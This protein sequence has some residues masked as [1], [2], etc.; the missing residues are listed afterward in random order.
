M[1]KFFRFF[2]LAALVVASASMAACSDKGS[3]ETPEPGNNGTVIPNNGVAA[4]GKIYLDTSFGGIYFG[5]FWDEG[6]GDYYIMLTN[7]EVGLTGNGDAAPMN[8]GGWILFLDFWGDL[9]ADHTNPILPEG[10]YQ[11]GSERGPNVLTSSYTL[12]VNNLERVEVEGGGYA[13]RII[14]VLFPSGSATVTHTAKGY[15]I[16]AN[17]FDVG[18]NPIN[19]VYE[20]EIVFEDKSDDEEFDT[21]INWDVNLQ[22]K[23]VFSA[24]YAEDNQVDNYV[25]TLFDVDT[26]TA[27]GVNPGE[28]GMKLQL[29]LYCED[30]GSFAGTYRIGTLSDKGILTKE[31]WV[32]YPGRYWGTTALGTFLEYLHTDY[33]TVLYSVIYGGEIVISE[34][35]DGT[36]RI[37]VD[38]ISE[39][40]NKVECDWSGEITPRNV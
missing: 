32:Y 11:L 1:K 36:Y 14:N 33:Q 8:P 28:P 13:Y 5:D 29:D 31:P 15:R 25:I 26:L 39:T 37:Q 21:S 24:Y 3:K 20:G 30:G 6:I 38:L 40:G 19:F 18:D 27:D 34:N 23:Q 7:D 2:A 16:E 4:D 9:S 10:T 22:P 12:A 17:M 35:G